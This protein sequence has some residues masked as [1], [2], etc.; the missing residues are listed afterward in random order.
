[1]G[2]S[3]AG[4]FKTNPKKESPVKEISPV[5]SLKEI[6]KTGSGGVD[7]KTSGSKSP[8]FGS[9]PVVPSGP[10]LE[11]D[12]ESAALAMKPMYTIARL[13]Q[14]P[15]PDDVIHEQMEKHLSTEE[16]HDMFKM[17]RKHW[18]AVPKWKKLTIK[19]D[20]GLF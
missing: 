9:R 19:K 11:E 1:L 6:P 12:A 17:T 3:L 18:D 14:R 15:L 13:K 7:L 2:N 4:K 8:R 10:V 20:V 5:P 16:F